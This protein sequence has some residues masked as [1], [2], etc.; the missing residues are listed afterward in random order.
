VGYGPDPEACLD[1]V[2]ARAR[3]SL[4]GNHDYALL[5]GAED[6]NPLAAE[7]IRLTADRMSAGSAAAAFCPHTATGQCPAC[8][9]MAQEPAARWQYLENLDLSRR[10]GDVLY[11]HGSPLNPVF[12]YVFP[13]RCGRAWLPERVRKIMD[14]VPWVAFCGHTHYPCAISSEL[15]CYYPGDGGVEVQLLPQ[16]R[17]LVNLG[18]VG[19][20]RDGD[21]RASYVLFDERERTVEW[22]RLPYDIGSV[23]KRIE[24]MCGRGNWCAKRLWKGR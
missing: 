10:E 8:L 18:S 19:Q 24:A 16:H 2:M 1:L 5:H 22:R 20:P 9:A 11:V 12:E 15:E 14:A 21:P 4:M 7:V 13:D 17:Y 3:W 6:F 23:A